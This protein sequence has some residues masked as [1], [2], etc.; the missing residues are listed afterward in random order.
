MKHQFK[1]LLSMSLAVAIMTAAN[2]VSEVYNGVAS[3]GGEDSPIPIER[4]RLCHK[5]CKAELVNGEW[6][7]DNGNDP[8]G[9]N[10]AT[11]QLNLN[12]KSAMSFAV[13]VES[14]YLGGPIESPSSS[15][16]LYLDIMYVDGTKEYGLTHCFRNCREAG[17][18]PGKVLVTPDKPVKHA[19]CYMLFRNRAGAA[20]FRNPK[21]TIYRD[22]G[23]TRF[24]CT[25]VQTIASDVPASF[26][27]HDA[28]NDGDGWTAFSDGEAA[29]GV[30]LKLKC[31]KRG[32]AEFFEVSLHETTGRDRAFTFA[33]SIP[34]PPGELTWLDTPRS[35]MKM[36]HGQYRSTVNVGC[37]EGMLSRWPFGAVRA[38]GE[39]LALGYDPSAPAV[40]RVTANADLR[41]L[42]IA[43]DVGFAKEK[44]DAKFRF[45]AF[46]S[47]AAEGFRGAL[48]KYAEIFP[49]AFRVRIRK[50]GI[51]MAFR[52]ISKVEGWEDFGFR[53]KEGDGE[54][55]W[56]DAH[57]IL[58]FHYSEPT[59]WWMTM[60]TTNTV[61]MVDAL[62]EAER[63]AADTR[64]NQYRG[65]ARAWKQCT[66][67]DLDGKIT[68]NLCDR[69]W[70][71]GA[72]WNL[73]PLPKIPGGDYQTKL[74]VDDFNRRYSKPF[75][76]GVD[77]EYIDS[78][79]CHLPP[80]IDFNRSNFRYSRTPL[81]FDRVSRMPGVSTALAIYEYVS[82]VAERMHSG[83][84]LM[85][86]NGAPYNWPWLIP[87]IDYGGQETKWIVKGEGEWSPMSDNDL[88]YRMA[89][90]YGKPYCFLM[91]VNFTKLTDEMV[92]KYFHRCLA[93]GL[94]SSFFSHNASEGHYFTRPELY[95]RHRRFFKKYGPL[96]RKVSEAGWRP[97]N[98]LVL[99]QGGEKVYAEQFGD[100]LATVFNSSTNAVKVKLEPLSSPNKAMELVTGCEMNLPC[101]LELPGETVR[102]LEFRD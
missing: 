13:S 86:A 19:C 70:C 101:E 5:G 79:E 23:F 15:Y 63:L 69:P 54:P 7:F 62:A 71:K 66:Y 47:S 11:F 26:M 61:T 60:K 68:G 56:D 52:P 83:G 9:M 6:R 45:V 94:M 35:E 18:Q 85:Q 89:L 16:S 75:P 32:M 58:T 36:E 37:G 25:K 95:N 97:V 10:G 20:A 14:A 74:S 93:Y 96:Q 4:F 12:Q 92:E 28:A 78:A 90:A 67:H 99:A 48:A 38:G 82:D 80:R 84:R 24:D 77:G 41:R 49:E 46:K 87:F 17:W 51:W 31:E 59:S 72:C 73:N 76:A 91:N 88:L 22:V 81:C 39:T 55:A 29:K 3:V 42:F 53:V 40:F 65:Y 98:R 33:Y 57:D 50:H 27:V 44:S 2:A 30:E 34:L 100:K 21:L 8:R 64:R 1:R 43:F 102:V